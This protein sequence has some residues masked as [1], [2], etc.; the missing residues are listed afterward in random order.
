MFIKVEDAF[1]GDLA[2]RRIVGAIEI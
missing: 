2:S 1:D